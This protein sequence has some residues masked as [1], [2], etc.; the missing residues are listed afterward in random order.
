MLVTDEDLSDD[1]LRHITGWAFVHARPKRLGVAVSGG[2]DSMALLDLM[3]WHAREMGF[4]VEAVTVDH[5]LRA[6]ARDEIALVRAYCDAQGVP[7]SVLAW[8]WDGEG[9]LQAAARNARYSLIAEWARER[10][11]DTV[12]LGH[13]QD[14]VAETFLMRLARRAG[15]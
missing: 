5:G 13:T 2:G 4:D 12:A 7:H 3:I 10:E 6:E 15:R 11:I 1:W 8:S 9:N 14:D